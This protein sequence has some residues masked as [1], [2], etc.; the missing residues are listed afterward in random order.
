M[1]LGDL[2]FSIKPC[3]LVT[4]SGS[5]VINHADGLTCRRTRSLTSCTPLL[6]LRPLS[7]FTPPESLALGWSLIRHEIRASRQFK[8]LHNLGLFIAVIAVLI[9]LHLIEIGWWSLS[10]ASFGFFPD[11]STAF[12]FSL[13]T[14]ATLGYG[15]VLLPRASR[16]LKP[17][18]HRP[19]IVSDDDPTESTKFQ[20]LKVRHS[21]GNHI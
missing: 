14:D 11:Q 20:N 12:Y 13:T 10:Y 7:P 6:W 17:A 2:S 9:V 15:D 18:W 1:L 4:T 8:F 16:I 19:H 3:G 21:V 5:V